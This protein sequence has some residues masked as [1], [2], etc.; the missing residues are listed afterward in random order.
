MRDLKGYLH[1]ATVY[2]SHTYLSGQQHTKKKLILE[3][4]PFA[5]YGKLYLAPPLLLTQNR[6]FGLA[7]GGNRVSLSLLDLH[8]LVGDSLDITFW[9]PRSCLATFFR[10]FH[11]F[12]PG[13]FAV[14][15][16]AY[17]YFWCYLK[18]QIVNSITYT[19][20]H[21]HIPFIR[22]VLKIHV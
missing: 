7:V 4:N 3:H 11:V 6:L 19:C 22:S 16:C 20:H 18:C 5:S 1:I 17:K 10:D 8:P 12:A 21:S 15:S 13:H 9:I 2:K 14:R